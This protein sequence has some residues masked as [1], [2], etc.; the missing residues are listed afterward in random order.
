MT[1]LRVEL[2]G[3][4]VDFEAHRDGLDHFGL[5]IQALSIAVPLLR[6]TGA[7]EQGERRAHL[8]EDLSEGG[9][10]RTL[11]ATAP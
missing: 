11:A 3:V 4:Q 1:D 9:V 6:S 5:G 2:D 7:D 8:A 10:H